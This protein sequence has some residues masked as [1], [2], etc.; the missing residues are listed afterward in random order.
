MADLMGYIST[1]NR[2]ITEQNG[3]MLA[4]LLSL[5]V[6]HQ[7]ITSEMKSLTSK[8]SGNN[9]LIPQCETRVTGGLGSIIGCRISTLI[10]IV[11]EDWNEANKFSIAMYN[12]ILNAFREEE[13]GWLIPVVNTVSND[14]RLLATKV[15]YIYI[16]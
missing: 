14:V 15:R 1:A 3:T 13:A 12:A 16:C 2:Y 5:P 4:R 9:S 6:G 11:S 7:T 10:S 8:T